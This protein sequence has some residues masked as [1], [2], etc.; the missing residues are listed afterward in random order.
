MTNKD[1]KDIDDLIQATAKIKEL[2][3]KL[4]NYDEAVFLLSMI[5]FEGGDEMIKVK[6]LQFIVEKYLNIETPTDEKDYSSSQVEAMK[7]V[8][9]FQNEFMKKRIKDIVNDK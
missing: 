2:K 7:A 5:V 4:G 3:E 9:E 6:S 1:L 8:E